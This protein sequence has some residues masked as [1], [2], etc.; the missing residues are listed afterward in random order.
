VPT[1]FFPPIPIKILQTGV[2][3]ALNAPVSL[4]IPQTGAKPPSNAPESINEDSVAQ[5]YTKIYWGK[6]PERKKSQTLRIA[7]YTTIQKTRFAKL[8]QQSESYFLF[9]QNRLI[10]HPSQASD[11]PEQRS[12]RTSTPRA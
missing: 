2:K 12:R 10:E 6:A 1:A 11:L 3:Q 5:I 4:K 7:K 8:L 9:P